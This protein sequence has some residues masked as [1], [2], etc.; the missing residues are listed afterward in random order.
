MCASGGGGGGDA[1]AAAAADAR[2]REEERQARFNEGMEAIDRLFTR[3]EVR[4]EN[5]AW[6][7]WNR[8]YGGGGNA[9]G[10]LFGGVTRP[11][12]PPAPERWV[13]TPSGVAFNDQFYNQR[14]QAYRDFA[15][16]QVEEQAERARQE[17]EFA[18]ARQRLTRS[19]VAGDRQ[20]DFGL[21]RGRALQG[22]EMTATDLIGQARGDVASARAQAVNALTASNDP[23]AALSVARERVGAVSTPPS[24]NPM[25]TLFANTLAS[26]GAGIGGYRDMQSQQ[27]GASK[28]GASLYGASSGS[29]RVV[30]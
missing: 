28:G 29:G 17:M 25:G 21:E 7:E 4:N 24:F 8:Q 16:P 13:W 18:L 19:S 27:Q 23:Q 6:T 11:G 15:M 30:R 9:L 20:R 1:A 10:G 3:G 5:P 26:A 2:R 14:A 12:A 22:V